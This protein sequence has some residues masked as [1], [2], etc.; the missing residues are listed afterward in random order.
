[1][2]RGRPGDFDVLAFADALDARRLE[3]GL[4]WAGVAR[5]I[6]SL[7][8]ELNARRKD[9]PISPGTLS[10][11]RG[12]ANTSCQHALFML[13]WLDLAPESFV[14]GQA[15]SSMAAAFPRLGADRRLR[16]DLGRLAE[17]MDAQR[18][19]HGATWNQLAGELACTPSQL[20][21]IRTARFATSMVLAM[22]IVAWL[23][24]SSTDFVYAARW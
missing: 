1:V 20:T 8:S 6:W 17:A 16:W 22:R 4:S 7:S 3:R 19:A 5:E 9:H 14:P 23:G 12:R 24:R 10:G 21:G 18:N 2:G 15:K 13:R 11:M